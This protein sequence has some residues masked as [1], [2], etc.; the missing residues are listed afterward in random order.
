[1]SGQSILIRAI[2]GVGLLACVTMF[3]GCSASGDPAAQRGVINDF[4][5]LYYDQQIYNDTYWMGVAVQKTPF[6]LW[7]FQ[8]IINDIRPDVL[9]EAGTYMGGSAYYFASLMDLMDHGQVVTI[10][11]VEQETW[12][13]HPRINYIVGSSTSAEVIEQVKSFINEGDTVM[14]TLDSDHTG[15][16]VLNELRL[17]S[18]LVTPGSYLVVE[19][20]QFNGHPIQP[21]WGPGPM[22]ALEEFLSENDDFEVDESREKFLFTFNPSG[23]LR[24]RD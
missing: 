6:D 12:P 21:N 11:I 13:R 24:K 23:Y 16:H 2:A 7:T 15:D 1:M 3:A 17:Y 18:D 8:E 14:V 20:T 19:D 9:V 22:E 5:Q 4:H 10:D